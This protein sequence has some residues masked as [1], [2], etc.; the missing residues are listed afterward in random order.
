LKIAKSWVQ[1]NEKQGLSSRF[2]VARRKR[3]CG[4]VV[5]DDS[6]IR[7]WMKHGIEKAGFV[8]VEALSAEEAISRH[9]RDFIAG[10]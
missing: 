8:I 6:L 4:F 1:V 5:E 9:A 3:G 2:A 10:E 7:Q